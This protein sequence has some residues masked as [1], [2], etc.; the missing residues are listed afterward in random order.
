MPNETERFPDIG[1]DGYPDP[2]DKDDKS[3][4]IK[5]ITRL[6]IDRLRT[7]LERASRPLN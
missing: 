4:G 7:A 3:W 5:R 6:A 1:E 2:P